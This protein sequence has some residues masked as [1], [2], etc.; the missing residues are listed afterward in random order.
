VSSASVTVD[1]EI[2]GQIQGGIVALIGILDGDTEE[3]LNHIVAKLLNVKMWPDGSGKMWNASVTDRGEELLIVSQ[4]T[5][6]ASFK[7]GGLQSAKA[8]R[9]DYNKSMSPTTALPMYEALLAKLRTDYDPSKIAAGTFGAKMDVALVNDGPVTIPID[10]RKWSY[11]NSTPA[12]DKKSS[13]VE[14]K[15]TKSDEAPKAVKKQTDPL[16]EYEQRA[17][18][19]EKK[20]ASLEAKYQALLL[21]V[22]RGH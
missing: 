14:E 9:P 1:S 2:V 15:P 20:L 17:T 21:Q 11:T 6:A 13:K 18:S 8:N 3:D 22:N 5:L 4:F 10:T 12:A 16:H 19:A 7:S